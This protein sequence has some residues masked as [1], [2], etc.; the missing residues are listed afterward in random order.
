MSY[1]IS[2][3][4]V[5]GYTIE[6][7]LALPTLTVCPCCDK[8]IMTLR[9]AFLLAENLCLLADGPRPISE[10][11]APIVDRVRGETV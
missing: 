6:F 5:R 9:R 8:P 7:S 11:I 4:S 10:V 2:G 1:A 3:D